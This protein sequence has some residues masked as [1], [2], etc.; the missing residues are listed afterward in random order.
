MLLRP[1]Q[2][3]VVDNCLQALQQNDNTLAVVPTGGGKTIILSSV[4][5]RLLRTS[6]QKALVLQHRDELLTQNA[7]KFRKVNPDIG[8]SIYN[9]ERK[10]WSGE[11][12]FASEPTLRRKAN[13]E[14]MPP[15]D[16]VVVDEA[17]HVG[18]DGYKGIL[19]AARELNPKVK[20]FG[21]TATPNRGDKV[22]LDHAFTNVGDQIKIHELIASGHLVRPRT[23]VIDLGISEELSR[24]RKTVSDFDMEEVAAIMDRPII[25]DEVVRHWRE[26]AGDRRTIA[27][28][29]TIAHA[30]HVAETFRG[31]GV[32]AE[33]VH[34]ELS[35]ERRK[36]ILKSYSAGKIQV[37]V[38]VAI[39]TEGFDDQPTSCIILLRPCSYKSTMIQMAGRGLRIVDPS[40]HPGIIKTDCVLLDFGRSILTHGTLEQRPDL[41]P[42]K[43]C[44]ACSQM[45]EYGFVCDDCP[46]AEERPDPDEDEAPEVIADPLTRVVMSEIDLFAKSNFKWIDLFGDDMAL[47]A[48][49]FE[50]WAGVFCD[51]AGRWHSIGGGKG[52]WP[53]LLGAGER[54]VAIALGDDWMNEHESEDGAHKTRRWLKLPATDTQMQWLDEYKSEGIDS[55]FN[56]YHASCL[57][58]FK[59]ARDKI[60]R[61]VLQ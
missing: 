53:K 59:F 46:P 33:V 24:V 15:F 26:K 16:L 61:I 19:K 52:K 57:M 49:G 47:M 12:V 55:G 32:V 22:A 43:H 17:H 58:N 37:L 38:N 8:I 7:T 5:G 27:F 39:L 31:A 9:A 29:S 6:A 34:S 4:T 42:M 21:V 30:E 44:K 48:S 36:A 13:L 20:L 11:T 56:R 14:K 23:F 2:K 54:I 40:L 45:V 50:A 10:V 1:Y 60:K 51:P 18:A 28:C 25:N 3:R 41:H 35:D